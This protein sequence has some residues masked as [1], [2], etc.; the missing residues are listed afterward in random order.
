[1]AFI[2]TLLSLIS[3]LSSALLLHAVI[4]GPKPITLSLIH[5][6]S[7]HSPFYPGNITDMEKIDILIHVT[8]ARIHH[9]LSMMRERN[10][11]G[12]SEVD[13]IVATVQYTGIYFVAQ[14]GIGSFPAFS[15]QKGMPYLLMIDTGS[16]LTWVQCEGCNPCFP[17]QQPNFPYNR[18]QSY[19]SIPCGDPTCP[20][21]NQ[22]CFQSFCGFR[23]DYGEED[24]PTSTTGA[25]IRETLTFPSDFGGTESYNDLF[26]GC[27]FMNYH[28][29]FGQP[30]KIGGI[31]G[32][33]LGYTE[34][35]PF[36]NQVGK[37]RFSYCLLNSEHTNS[38]LYIGGTKMVGPQVLSTPLLRGSNEALYYLDLQDISIQNIHLRLQGLFSGGSAIDS[39][40]PITILLPNVYARV[41]IGFVQYFEQFHIQ[42]YSSGSRPKGVPILDLCF[43]NPS[44][45]DRYPTMTFHFRGANLVVQ[46]DGI[47]MFG[48]NYI[49]V[50]LKSGPVTLIGA[51]QQTQ[52]KFSYD[53]ELGDRGRGEIGALRF[54]PQDCGSPA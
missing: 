18:S 3:L 22:D 52:H 54:A 9:L 48:R 34:T 7:P 30:N 19:K 4:E 35:L 10:W 39:G 47:F 51:F 21:P 38:Q 20:T 16:D 17:L 11:N 27:S 24:P 31:L 26:L 14:V 1:M 44:G 32:L 5:P 41:R 23:I 49:C 36:L 6:F 2:E 46:P 25:I 13:D 37:K 50:L 42:P 15:G 33:G 12:S 40:C 28:H 29:E 43:P 53:F 8:N 45:F